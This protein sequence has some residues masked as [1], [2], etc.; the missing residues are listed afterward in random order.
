MVAEELLHAVLRLQ[1]LLR[2]RDRGG[3]RPAL[4]DQATHGLQPQFSKLPCC[5]QHGLDL[6]FGGAIDSLKPYHSSFY[7]GKLFLITQ[8]SSI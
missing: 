1:L 2:P 3:G 4:P 7:S 6:G 8:I 5:H